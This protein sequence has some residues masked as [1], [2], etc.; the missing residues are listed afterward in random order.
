MKLQDTTLELWRHRAQ[1]GNMEQ[2]FKYWTTAP[3]AGSHQAIHTLLVLFNNSLLS[4]DTIDSCL[5]AYN[6]SC[7]EMRSEGENFIRAFFNGD[8]QC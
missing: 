2:A 1:S 7:A 6:N 8:V 5:T 4:R 3:S